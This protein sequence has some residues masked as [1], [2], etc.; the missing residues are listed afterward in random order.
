[1]EAGELSSQL[2]RFFQQDMATE[3]CTM[4]CASRNARFCPACGTAIG[5]S[6]AKVDDPVK[7]EV[8]KIS[9][10]QRQASI[11][12]PGLFVAQRFDRIEP[13]GAA[14]GVEAEEDADG[15]GEEKR[16]DRRRGSR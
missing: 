6:E 10:V 16:D 12:P 15:G 14:G 3:K 1:M 4:R 5:G 2:A 7:A 13:A 9:D 11:G 8:E